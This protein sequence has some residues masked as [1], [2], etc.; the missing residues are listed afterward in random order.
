MRAAVALRDTCHPENGRQLA[1]FGCRSSRGVHPLLVPATS[2]Y[3]D[4]CVLC[5]TVS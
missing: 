3:S 2:A 4:P 5:D 1:L